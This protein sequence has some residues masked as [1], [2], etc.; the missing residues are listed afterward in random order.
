VAKMRE[1]IKIKGMLGGQTIRGKDTWRFRIE[2][3]SGMLHTV[4]IP[5]TMYCKEIPC[6]LLSPQ[7]WRKQKSVISGTYCKVSNNC[8][9]LTCDEGRAQRRVKLDLKNNCGIIRSA[10]DY[11]KYNRLLAMMTTTTSRSTDTRQDG[12]ELING[13]RNTPSEDP[14]ARFNF[15]KGDEQ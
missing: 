7:H 5:N 15:D 2:D 14:T 12:I 11:S 4:E 1:C 3:D 13:Q 10:S 8:M 6:H 9:D